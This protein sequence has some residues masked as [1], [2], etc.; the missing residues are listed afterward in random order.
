MRL[1]SKSSFHL[2]KVNLTLL[3][4]QM[5]YFQRDLTWSHYSI[6]AILESQSTE[7]ASI[8]IWKMSLLALTNFLR[9]HSA[10]VTC[11]NQTKKGVKVPKMPQSILQMYNFS[12]PELWSQ[13]NSW[14][15]GVMQQV[16]PT[17]KEKVA[18]FRN[19]NKWDQGQDKESFENNFNGTN[20][21]KVAGVQCHSRT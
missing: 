9:I 13:G 19:E 14:A 21:S 5:L 8:I 15:S 2:L 1:L 20:S 6:L 10:K 4:A 12:F 16:R 3:K 17:F 11:K 7:N 18:A